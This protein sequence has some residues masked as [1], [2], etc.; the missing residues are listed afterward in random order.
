MKRLLVLALLAL[1]LTIV[2]V[3]TASPARPNDADAQGPPCGEITNG[4]GAYSLEGVIDFT[5]F[6]QAPACSFVTY[7]FVVTDTAGNTLTSVSPDAEVCTPET[8]SGGCVHFSVN[9]GASGPSPVCV[10]ATTTIGGHLIDRAPNLSDFPCP[11]SSPSTPLVKGGS[12][13]SGG[14]G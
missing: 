7:T 9:L 12:G 11:E 13:A 6:L 3:P 14:F 10:Y 1:G 5:V 8:P 2:V 4:D